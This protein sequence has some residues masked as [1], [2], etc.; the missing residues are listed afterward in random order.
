MAGWTAGGVVSKTMALALQSAGAEVVVLAQPEQKVGSLPLLT[1][2]APAYWPGE[3]TLRKMMGLPSR[4]TLPAFAKEARLDVLLPVVAP[5]SGRGLPRVGWIPDLQ[6]KHLPELF[7]TDQ[8]A[9]LDRRFQ[10]LTLSSD[11]MIFS[12][13]DSAQDF[14]RFFPGFEN[15]ISVASFPS[16]FAFEPPAGDPRE[17]CR[18]FHLPEKFLLVVNQFWR[19]KNHRVVAKALGILKGRNRRIT[20]VM[21]GMPA[22][23]RDKENSSLSETMQSAAAGRCW[24]DCLI[25]GKLTREQIEGL[26]RSATALVQPSRFEGWNTSV[27]DAKA[28]GCPLF[29]S[30]L[31]VHREQCPDAQGFFDCD[32]AEALADLL[33]EQWDTLPARPDAQ[34]ET[35]ALAE[36]AVRAKA[37]GERLQNICREAIA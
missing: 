6:H 14:R 16:L 30:D 15:R 29:L 11:R 12:S 20:V 4:N 27:E 24:E 35:Q 21:A 7:P 10:E 1:P 2:P 9:I 33:A 37:Y 8:L 31:P 13:E 32:N 22:D 5:L 18:Q 36:T 19:H 28:L 26:L 25:L 23:Y 3:W 34:R 17:V